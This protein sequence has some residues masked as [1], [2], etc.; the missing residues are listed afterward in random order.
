MDG[1]GERNEIHWGDV[2]NFTGGKLSDASFHV[3]RS[4][5]ARSSLGGAAAK[6]LASVENASTILDSLKHLRKDLHLSTRESLQILSSLSKQVKEQNGA[7]VSS[8]SHTQDKSGMEMEDSD[9][10]SA[11]QGSMQDVHE[12]KCIANA[13]AAHEIARA[14]DRPTYRPLKERVALFLGV[15]DGDGTAD[16]YTFDASLHGSL[17]SCMHPASGPGTA[18]Y[19]CVE[20]GKVRPAAVQRIV[21]EEKLSACGLDD[22]TGNTRRKSACRAEE[23]GEVPMEF[24]FRGTIIAKDERVSPP[25]WAVVECDI[26]DL[27]RF[28]RTCGPDLGF[29]HDASS[30]EHIVSEHGLSRIRVPRRVMMDYIKANSINSVMPGA[31]VRGFAGVLETA[32]HGRAPPSPNMATTFHVLQISHLDEKPRKLLPI[33]QY[34][35]AMR[36]KGAILAAQRKRI[37]SEDMTGE[38]TD[39]TI[40]VRGSKHEHS[41]A[42]Q[43]P[44]LRITPLCFGPGSLDDLHWR[45][46]NVKQTGSPVGI[47]MPLVDRYQASYLVISGCSQ[48]LVMD[49]RSGSYGD[50]SVEEW[51]HLRTLVID[52]FLCE[53]IIKCHFGIDE[54]LAILGQTFSLDL[55]ERNEIKNKSPLLFDVRLFDWMLCTPIPDADVRDTNM[56]VSERCLLKKD[57]QQKQFQS[58]ERCIENY[59]LVPFTIS[60]RLNVVERIDP[61]IWSERPLSSFALFCMAEQCAQVAPLAILVL[62]KLQFFD[63]ICSYW[64]D[65]VETFGRKVSDW[66]GLFPEEVE[67]IVRP[68]LPADLK[69]TLKN[70]SI[71]LSPIGLSNDE[72]FDSDDEVVAKNDSFK[73]KTPLVQYNCVPGETLSI[74]LKMLNFGTRARALADMV[75]E[76]TTCFKFAKLGERIS[77]T[78][79]EPGHSIALEGRFRSEQV[80]MYKATIRIAFK[81]ADLIPLVTTIGIHVVSKDYIGGNRRG[82]PLSKLVEQLEREESWSFGQCVQ[83]WPLPD[84]LRRAAIR[85]YAIPPELRGKSRDFVG[86]HLRGCASGKEKNESIEAE[87]RAYADR[88]HT[89]LWLEEEAL[90]QCAAKYSTRAKVEVCKEKAGAM[91]CKVTLGKDLSE[92]RPSVLPDDIVYLQRAGNQVAF[93]ARVR[94]V[95]QKSLRLEPA[96]EFFADHRPEALYKISFQF[97]RTSLVRAHKALDAFMKSFAELRNLV[98]ERSLTAAELRRLQKEDEV[99]GDNWDE[100]SK[101]N[102]HNAEQFRAVDLIASLREEKDNSPYLVFG[103]PGTGKTLVLVDAIC[104]VLKKSP[105]ERILAC[106]P[107][108]AAAD[109]IAS[110]LMSRLKKGVLLRYKAAS[111]GVKESVSAEELDYTNWNDDEGRF[112]QHSHEK[113]SKYSVLVTTC[114]MAWTLSETSMRQSCEPLIFQWIFV[115]EAGY[116]TE[117]DLLCAFA[118]KVT[119]RSRVILFGDPKQLGPVVMSRVAEKAGLGR[120]LMERIFDVR[121]EL[122]RKRGEKRPYR[123]SLLTKNYRS[124]SA[125]IEFSNLRFYG[126]KLESDPAV[127]ALREEYRLATLLPHISD[128]PVAFIEVFGMECRDFGSPSFYNKA[129]IDVSERIVQQVIQVERIELAKIGFITPYRR[130]AEEFRALAKRR[131]WHDI[132]VGSVEVFQGCEKDVIIYSTVRGLG[133]NEHDSPAQ[134]AFLGNEK[135]FNVAATRA[136][137]LFFVV[138]NPIALGKL[139]LMKSFLDMCRARN[140]YVTMASTLHGKVL[141][142]DSVPSRAPNVAGVEGGTPWTEEASET[143]RDCIPQHV[144]DHAAEKEMKVAA[145][146]IEEKGD[147]SDPRKRAERAEHTT[148]RR[149]RQRR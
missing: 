44:H 81:D 96:K 145:D 36:Q 67:S 86:I 121:V 4:G 52:F 7:R 75:V 68:R 65:S 42:Y 135:R 5:K 54:W 15:A 57:D 2:L 49:V 148:A 132:Q 119:S 48:I 55:A 147:K 26:D 13:D 38:E 58:L 91:M 69:S 18:A 124:H 97:N 83:V 51:S 24:F 78:A 31:R 39:H 10:K 73:L 138:G 90:E 77:S 61:Y 60:S 117:P 62:R 129:E 23:P 133:E 137:R 21:S 30:W 140:A 98:F 94:K 16:T 9:K 11:L 144:D 66:I 33:P 72:D 123:M 93:E 109:V 59:S 128:F 63:L 111:C 53:R 12:S 134:L 103:P 6:L 64:E 87:S 118:N 28:L 1:E 88:L 116:A 112:E 110:R 20:D 108:N 101:E 84:R 122:Q 70:H 95:L 34:R 143:A 149:V 3:E 107:S 27:I 25:S 40:H 17:D 120:S 22:E 92:M 79:V 14:P 32:R 56:H 106:A 126:G 89:L 45:L 80:G 71:F 113:L 35:P 125:I 85:D 146:A 82:L 8:L 114:N 41:F 46:E 99:L 115:D 139:P 102:L 136:Q 130:Q 104:A 100:P 127:E 29:R 76:G 74:D 131:K 50:K 141:S 105:G 37:L 19:E 47:A 43:V 142:S